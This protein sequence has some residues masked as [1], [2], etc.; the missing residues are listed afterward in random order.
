MTESFDDFISSLTETP[1][2]VATKKTKAETFPCGQCHGTGR[3]QGARVHQEKSHCFACKGTGFFKTDPRKL[4]EQSRKR[5]ESKA[6][7]LADGVANF[8]NDHPLVYADLKAGAELGYGFA[9]DLH[10]ALHKYGSLTENQLAACYRGIAKREQAQVARAAEMKAA[11]VVD[12]SPIKEMFDRAVANGYKKPAYRAE[13]LTIKRAP[14]HGRNAG[15]LYVV[16]HDTDAY[17]GKVMGG[18][19]HKVRETEASTLP[20]LLAIAADPLGAAVRYGNKTGTCSCC[21]RPLSNAE[22]VELGI[23]PI[24]RAKWF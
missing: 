23:G 16:I 24:C 8:K 6:A 11:P 1:L 7:A 9:S 17:Q 19:F 10:M 18:Q 21:G 20:A 5:R 14:D 3:Y 2:P 12:L 4:Q 22:S 13:G 15:A